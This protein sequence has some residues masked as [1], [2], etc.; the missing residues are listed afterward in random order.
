MSTFSISTIQRQWQT[1]ENEHEEKSL[2]DLS[3]LPPGIPS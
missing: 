1:D 2:S 3:V